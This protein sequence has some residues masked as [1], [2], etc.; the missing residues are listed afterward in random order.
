MEVYAKI[1]DTN[2]MF[3]FQLWEIIKKFNNLVMMIFIYIHNSWNL[4]KIIW[5]IK[6][7][8][9]L[10]LSWLKNLINQ[11]KRLIIYQNYQNN[12]ILKIYF[13]V[14]KSIINFDVINL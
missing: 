1:I 10:K 8:L 6:L 5:K 11:K 2:Q 12:D 3:L 13:K 9:D 4:K 14:V 7:C